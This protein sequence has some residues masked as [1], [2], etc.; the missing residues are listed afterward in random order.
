MVFL[1]VLQQV[2]VDK[3]ETEEASATLAAVASIFALKKHKERYRR[4]FL[5]KKKFLTLL[6]TCFGKSSNTTAA[7]WAAKHI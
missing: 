5:V 1:L 7:H 4:L 2:E 3:E 6:Q